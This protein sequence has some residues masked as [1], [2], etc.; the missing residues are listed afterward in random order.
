LEPA[1]PVLPQFADGRGYKRIADG[2]VG[3]LDHSVLLEQYAGR[4]ESKA[5]SPHWR[6]GAYA[7]LEHRAPERVVLLYAVEWDDAE[8]A[9]R[10][11]R[12]YRQILEKKWK[13]L[14]IESESATMVSGAGDD[15]HFLVRLTGSVVTSLEGAESAAVPVR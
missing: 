4:E 10:Y 6:G 13:H 7:L 15:G 14:A 11:F 5:V 8:W 2:T 3:E 9:G 1:R 12:L